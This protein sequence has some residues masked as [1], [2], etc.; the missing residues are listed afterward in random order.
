MKEI[1]NWYSKEDPF[2]KKGEVG[3]HEIIHKHKYENRKYK[4]NQKRLN[5]LC[6]AEKLIGSKI[7]GNILEVGAGD[8]SMSVHLAKTRSI[9]KIYSM[10]CTTAAVDHLIRCNFEQNN[11]DDNK[12][13]L[14]LGSFNNIELKNYFDYVVALGALHH[15]GNLIRTIKSIYS[16]LR[17]GGYLI[18][19]EPYM[20]SNTPNSVFLQKEKNIKNVQ[21]IVSIRESDRDDHFFR[22]CEY[23]TAF[24]HS[25]FE[26]RFIDLP[27]MRHGEILNSLIVLK[28]PL[29]LADKIPHAWY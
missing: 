12:Y 5:Q 28:K 3:I 23:L 20:P 13:E 29:V 22:K 9:K 26:V 19:Q 27:N 10:E 14:V 1:T 7:S 21:G 18:A 25:G 11:I 16:A 8:G 2:L 6:A 24:Y 15:S 4:L 17:P